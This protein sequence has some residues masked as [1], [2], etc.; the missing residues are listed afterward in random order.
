[1]ESSKYQPISCSFYDVIVLHIMKAKEVNVFYKSAEGELIN[2]LTVLKDVYTS[3][4]EEF[5][6]LKDGEIIRLDR[7]MKIEGE[8]ASASCNISDHK[9]P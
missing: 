6:V 7:L 5:V 9:T 2:Q 4:G 3:K 8:E 1:M